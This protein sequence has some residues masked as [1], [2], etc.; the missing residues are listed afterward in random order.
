[1]P[2]RA[3]V[4]ARNCALRL[5]IMSVIA[6]CTSCT[7]MNA[8]QRAEAAAQRAAAELLGDAAKLRFPAAVP[9]LLQLADD[10]RAAGNQPKSQAAVDRLRSFPLSVDDRARTERLAIALLL[11]SRQAA[12]AL[13]LIDAQPAP[14]TPAARGQLGQLRATA[15]EQLRRLAEASKERAIAHTLIPAQARPANARQLLDDLGNMPRQQLLA[16]TSD[17]RL[18]MPWLELANLLYSGDPLDRQIERYRTWE[19]RWSSFISPAD[20]PD[21]IRD[22]PKLD[23][24]PPGKVALLLPASGALAPAARAVRD[25]FMAALFRASERR[26]EVV[27]ID[28]SSGGVLSAYD[29]AVAAGVQLVIGP[30]DKLDVQKLSSR[31]ALPVP[32][33]ALNYLPG[34]SGAV[35]GLFQ[36]GLAPEDEGRA[37]AEHARREGHSN[38]LLLSTPSDWAQRASATLKERWQQLDARLV[39]EDVLRDLPA[40]ERKMHDALLLEDP[41]ARQAAIVA[42]LG[43]PAE[44]E[45]QSRNR[46]D[47]IVLLARPNEAAIIMP[48]LRAQFTKELPVYASSHMNGGSGAGRAELAGIRFCDSPW[49]ITGNPLRS[50]IARLQP[51]VNGDSA[52][53]YA[54]GVDAYFLQDR[55]TLLARKGTQL[56]GV[57]G[58]LTL[59]PG[60]RIG[61]EPVWA[62]F[63]ATGNTPIE[64]GTR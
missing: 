25:G 8:N 27:A 59:L 5:L 16:L 34:K 51:A 11:D 24:R 46:I 47:V 54:L 61:R 21:G 50:T 15:L 49:R 56:S 41:A 48:T 40:I 14:A 57:T 28:V 1:M 42:A 38:L 10:A 19:M 52:N 3:F 64:S 7:A 53:L 2:L 36:F 31:G 35:N 22:M 20:L 13:I 12:N 37:I 4:S 29:Q 45:Q 63:T 60:N 32:V 58:Q 18:F 26:P 62:R 33:L 6:L 30:I 44:F 39:R 9:V 23:A 43:F 55:L 17:D